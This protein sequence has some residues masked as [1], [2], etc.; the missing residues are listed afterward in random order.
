M[1]SALR[2]SNL[3][4]KCV[5]LVPNWTNFDVFKLSFQKIWLGD[6]QKFK[7][8]PIWGQTDPLW[9]HICK[10][11]TVVEMAILSTLGPYLSSLHIVL[12]CSDSEARVD[13]PPQNSEARRNLSSAAQVIKPRNPTPRG[14]RFNSSVPT[15]PLNTIKS[16]QL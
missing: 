9:G 14:H 11:C 3:A 6:H 13:D 10:P 8:C 16:L 4:S 7:I 1:V 15:L 12:K 5:R 2:M